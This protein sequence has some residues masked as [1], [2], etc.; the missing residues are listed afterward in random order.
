MGLGALRDASLKQA[1]EFVTRWRFILHEGCAPIK[2]IR[3]KSVRQ[4][5]ILIILKTLL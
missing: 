2:N 1:R 5:T 4:Y 3:N